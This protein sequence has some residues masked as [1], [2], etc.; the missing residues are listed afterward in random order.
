MD[1]RIIQLGSFE[2]TFGGI[3]SATEVL[4]ACS[5]IVYSAM[6]LKYK[7]L[8]RS[9]LI[10]LVAVLFFCSFT[11]ILRDE[12]VLKWKA[13]IVNWIFA[14]IFFGSHIFN[15]SPKNAT[16]LMLDHAVSMPDQAW[17]RLNFAWAFFFLFLGSINLFVAFTFHEYWVDFKVFGSMGLIII[18]IIA[19][20]FYIAPYI[21]EDNEIEDIKPEEA[22]K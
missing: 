19:Q 13:P 12:A 22:P 20:T 18:F 7:K 8:E 4:V 16:Q 15:F 3:F 5:I 9:Q 11:I 10:T 14:G 21:Q 6:Y 2:H 17:D 1:E